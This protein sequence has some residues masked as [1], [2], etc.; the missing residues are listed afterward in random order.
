M[1]LNGIELHLAM[2]ALHDFLDDGQAQ[3]ATLAHIAGPHKTPEHAFAIG[4]G[5]ARPGVRDLQQ[6]LWRGAGPV[7]HHPHG[8]LAAGSGVMQRVVDQVGQ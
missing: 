1:G 5:Q 2:V 3:A 6:G 4:R 8:D 7:G